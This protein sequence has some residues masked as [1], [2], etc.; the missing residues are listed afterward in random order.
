[1]KR[2][3]RS[4]WIYSVIALLLVGAAF[5]G[6]R[7]FSNKGQTPG[8]QVA[9]VSNPGGES[10]TMVTELHGSRPS[11]LPNEPP[12]VRGVLDRRENASIFVGTGNLSYGTVTNPD[13]SVRVK[14]NYD[15]PVIEVVTTHDTVIYQDNME[16]Q[17]NGEVRET[18]E[19]G[20]LDK[21]SKGSGVTV[22]GERRGDRVVARVLSYLVV[23]SG[24]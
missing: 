10:T 14:V 1:M 20:S 13:G 22:W 7:L 9:E 17:K 2:M 24:K 21:I 5:M 6:G 16:A 8:N 11:E 3:K 12:V 23:S 15:G 18:L 19:P 4:I